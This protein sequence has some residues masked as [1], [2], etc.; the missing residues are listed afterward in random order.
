[1]RRKLT[2]AILCTVPSAL[3]GQTPQ[4]SQPGS[5]YPPLSG[6]HRSMGSGGSNGI[7]Y[8]NFTGSQ[9]LDFDRSANSSTGSTSVDSRQAVSGDFSYGSTTERNDLQF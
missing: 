6:I 7:L 4:Q 1:M 2:I 5:T 9:I 3:L 8:S